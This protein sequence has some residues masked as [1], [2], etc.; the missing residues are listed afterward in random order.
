MK[1][2]ELRKDY[3]KASLDETTVEKNPFIQFEKWFNEAQVARINE[4]NAMI[5]STASKDCKPSSRVVLLKEFSKDGF[6]FYMNYNSR[7]GNDLKENPYASLLFFWIDL[8]RQIRIEGKVSK[9]SQEESEKYFKSRP[10]K[11]RLGAWASNQS[12]V[13]KKREDIIKKFMIVSA[14]YSLTGVPLPDFWG[15]YRLKPDSIEF[16]QGRENRLHDRIRYRLE[17]NEW[18][19]ER[20][21]P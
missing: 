2:H 19:I 6:V 4:P 11:S 8:E 20:L 15:G 7:K 1:L 12:S 21:S 3:T 13:I 18:I 16:W 17:N 14:K 9:V 5:L 10:L